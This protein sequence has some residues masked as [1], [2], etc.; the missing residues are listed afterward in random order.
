MLNAL[1]VFLL[2]AAMLITAA[3]AV[4]LLSPLA[5]GAAQGQALFWGS[6]ALSGLLTAVGLVRRRPFRSSVRVGR[7]SVGLTLAGILLLSAGLSLL[8]A[9]LGLSDGGMNDLFS[10]M[11]RSPLCLLLLLVA[12]PL[13]E[14]LVFREG[15]LRSLVG[16]GV[17]PLTACA[18]SALLFALCHGNPAQALPAAV[19]GFVLGLLYL[20]TSD[21]RLCLPAHVA[22]N[23]LALLFLRFPAAGAFCAAL[24][25]LYVAGTGALLL[26]FG[27]AALWSGALRTVFS[28]SL[29]SGV[30]PEK[31]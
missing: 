22:N 9:P 13:A 1:L 15:I 19:L 30:R 8:L 10:D 24:P 25:P 11:L 23:A 29:S 3:S 6:L 14:E 27:V 28:E 31:K 2:Y 17:R 16:A 26:A 21:L 12:G 7:R 4:R 18:V 20:R 5:G